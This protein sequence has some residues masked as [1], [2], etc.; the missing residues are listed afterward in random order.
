MFILLISS[1]ISVLDS[2][3]V[4]V[5]GCASHLIDRADIMQLAPIHIDDEVLLSDATQLS[6]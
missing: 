5:L 3:S 6:V 1:I 2:C 4:K